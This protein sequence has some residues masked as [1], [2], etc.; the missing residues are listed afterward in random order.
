LT[1]VKAASAGNGRCFF[2]SR[3]PDATGV[4]VGQSDGMMNAKS[5]SSGSSRSGVKDCGLG[6]A[7]I[8]V[9]ERSDDLRSKDT[10]QS[11]QGDHSRASIYP[12]DARDC[13]TVWH[14][15]LSVTV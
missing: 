11:L 1:Q 9:S 2:K 12:A 8:K 10:H 4:L 13:D 3:F 15:G 7:N 5:S 14:A 6:T